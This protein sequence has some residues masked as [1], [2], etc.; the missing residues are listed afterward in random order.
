MHAAV[1]QAQVHA[2]DV[3]DWFTHIAAGVRHQ[4][5]SEA[6]DRRTRQ[7]SLSHI[8]ALHNYADS[9]KSQVFLFDYFCV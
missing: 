1:T 6:R 4:E 7:M 8:H 2:A 5:S 3:C 9:V